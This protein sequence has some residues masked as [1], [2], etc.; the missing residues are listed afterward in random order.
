LLVFL[1]FSIAPFGNFSADAFNYYYA[2]NTPKPNLSLYLPYSPK[3]VTSL[4]CPSTHHSAKAKQLL[5]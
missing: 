5:A 3:R 1:C 4:L 2:S